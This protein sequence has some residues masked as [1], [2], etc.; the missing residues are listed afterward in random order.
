MTSSIIRQMRLYNGPKPETEFLDLIYKVI[1]EKGG[2]TRP[3]LSGQKYLIM[4]I[5]LIY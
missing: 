2:G 4:K 5:T 3:L 1:E